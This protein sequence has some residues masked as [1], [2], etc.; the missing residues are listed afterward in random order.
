M[1][2]NHPHPHD[3]LALAISDCVRRGERRRHRLFALAL[4][5][6]LP[7]TAVLG[8][9]YPVTEVPAFGTNPGNLRMFEYVPEKLK[10]PAPVVIALHGCAQTASTYAEHS[11]WA[12]LAN[13]A[14]FILVLPQQSRRNNL[15]RCFNWFRSEDHRRNQGE[16]L[17]I[18]QMITSARSKY[19]VAKDK[20]FVTGLSAGGSMTAALLAAYPDLFSAGASVAGIPYRCGESLWSALRCVFRGMNRRP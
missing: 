9:Q 12:E 6:L 18:F 2:M 13:K 4:L 16:A 15:S 20:I 8:A 17:S 11:G 3:G 7:C 19:Q 5:V 14:G 10:K 1:A